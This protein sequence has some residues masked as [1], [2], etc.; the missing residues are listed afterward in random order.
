LRSERL[1]AV[2][3]AFLGPGPVRA[4]LAPLV[5]AS[6]AF[7][8]IVRDRWRDLEQTAVEA[9]LMEA[10]HTIWDQLLLFSQTN[11]RRPLQT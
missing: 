1:L 2:D 4:E 6:V 8:G 7:L 5:T 10:C 9:Y 11:G 3:W